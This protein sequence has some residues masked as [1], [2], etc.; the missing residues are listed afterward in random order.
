MDTNTLCN[1]IIE[2]Y[3]DSHFADNAYF[4]NHW[5]SWCFKILSLS[6]SPS[7]FLWQ[8]WQ[9]SRRQPMQLKQPAMFS[10]YCITFINQQ[11]IAMQVAPPYIAFSVLEITWVMDLMSGSVVWYNLYLWQCFWFHL[12]PTQVDVRGACVEY[13]MLKRI[14]LQKVSQLDL[15]WEDILGK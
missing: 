11:C 6:W 2:V 8:Q 13:K 14:I 9:K 7:G 4:K 15:I 1:N 5:F 10:F 3:L 12:H